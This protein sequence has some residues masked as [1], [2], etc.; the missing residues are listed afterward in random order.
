MSETLSFSFPISTKT[1]I[2]KTELGNKHAEKFLTQGQLTE[3]PHTMQQ[4]HQ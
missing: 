1:H 3:K 2:R 4:N